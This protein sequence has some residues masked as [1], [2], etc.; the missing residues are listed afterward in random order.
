MTHSVCVVT[1]PGPPVDK[2]LSG[3][4]GGVWM[5]PLLARGWSP[6]FA[7]ALSTMVF[8]FERPGRFRLLTNPN[9]TGSA[10][11]RKTIGIVVVAALR[12]ARQG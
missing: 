5:I 2:P 8:A 6:R 10:P 12:P 9:F 11:V 3:G 4:S 7:L 1:N